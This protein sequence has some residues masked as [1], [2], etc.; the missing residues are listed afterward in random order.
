MESQGS[1]LARTIGRVLVLAVAASSLVVLLDAGA[2][3]PGATWP[4]VSSYVRTPSAL[5]LEVSRP[6]FTPLEFRLSGNLPVERGQK[7]CA[8]APS[9]ESASPGGDEPF[10]INCTGGPTVKAVGDLPHAELLSWPGDSRYHRA[11]RF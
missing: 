4:T 10:D 3:Y 2:K 9:A 6:G 8:V 5:E 7:G 1:A 11:L